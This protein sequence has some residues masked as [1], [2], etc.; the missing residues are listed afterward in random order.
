L[1]G[2]VIYAGKITRY[3]KGEFI[4]RFGSRRIFVGIKEIIWRRQRIS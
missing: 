3:V 2:I 4:G 1:I